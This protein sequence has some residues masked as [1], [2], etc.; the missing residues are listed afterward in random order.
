M[1]TEY[2]PDDNG[3]GV[4]IAIE[5]GDVEFVDPLKYYW[6]REKE[7]VYAVT[8]TILRAKNPFMASLVPMSFYEARA[9]KIWEKRLKI[10]DET[11]VPKNFFELLSADSKKDQIKLLKGQSLTPNQL[12]AFICKAFSDH[13]YTFSNYTAHHHHKGLDKSA[14]PKLVKVEGDVVETAGETTLSE[15]QLKNVVNHRKVTVAK[16]LDKGDDW[17]CLFL[18]YRS[19]RGEE[20]W[21]NGQPHLHYISSKWGISRKEIVEQ[22]K[23]DNYLSTPVHIDLLDYN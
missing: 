1:A 22:L 5:G 18:T 15:G 17:H 13:G 16:F 12:F 21:K 4:T 8:S 10:I 19:L 9:K 3:K 7:R 2:I 6:E 23:S 20:S 11:A 14:L